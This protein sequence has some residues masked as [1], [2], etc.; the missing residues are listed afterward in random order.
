MDIFDRLALW[1]RRYEQQGPSP[2]RKR[3]NL[4]DLLET[5]DRHSIIELTPY[6]D[7]RRL[8][9]VRPDTAR[10]VKVSLL[11][12]GISAIH[13]STDDWYEV[14]R[15]AP[16]GDVSKVRIRAYSATGQRAGEIRMLVGPRS[17]EQY[18]REDPILDALR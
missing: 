6:T 12:D 9:T 17:F 4:S 7:G 1:G 13:S 11:D 5:F 2:S 3:F 18:F 16:T 15:T 8:T 14:F 10:K